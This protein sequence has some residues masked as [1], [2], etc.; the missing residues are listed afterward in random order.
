MCPRSASGRSGIFLYLCLQIVQPLQDSS[1]STDI[2][3]HIGRRP[4]AFF[5]HAQLWRDD[6]ETDATPCPSSDPDPDPAHRMRH[7]PE[8]DPGPDN[9]LHSGDHRHTSLHGPLYTAVPRRLRPAADV[10]VPAPGIR[11]S[12]LRIPV[13]TGRLRPGLRRSLRESSAA[14]CP[15][16][17]ADHHRAAENAAA[18]RRDN[19]YR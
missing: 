13:P 18:E 7:D 8:H 4:P 14:T 19:R 17:S 2:R 11:R 3:C 10:M 16:H 5:R 9:R 12:P 1:V 6:D 15:D